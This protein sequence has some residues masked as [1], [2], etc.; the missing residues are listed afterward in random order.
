MTAGTK[1]CA[2]ATCIPPSAET[3]C[4]GGASGAATLWP[5]RHEIPMS[6][7]TPYSL[8]PPTGGADGGG[9]HELAGLLAAGY[10]RLLAARASRVIPQI[11]LDVAGHNEAPFAM[12]VSRRAKRA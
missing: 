10:I 11:R 3:P 9:L 8:S 1:R 5:P 12:R 4:A 6:D 2:E 7:S